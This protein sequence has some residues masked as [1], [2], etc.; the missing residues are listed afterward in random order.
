MI[1]PARTSNDTSSTAGTPRASTTDIP[2][3]VSTSSV[4]FAGVWSMRSSTSRPT[5]IAGDVGLAQAGGGQRADGAP[6]PDHRDLVGDRQHLAQL[7]RDEQHGAAP[8]GE[9]ADDDEE[10]VDLAGREHGRRL[11]EDEQPGVVA[12]ALSTS[13]RWRRPTDRVDTLAAGSTC[14]PKRSL[15][16]RTRCSISGTSREPWRVVSSR[17][18]KTLAATVSEPTSLKC[19][20]TMPMPRASLLRGRDRRLGCRRRRIVARSPAAPSRRSSSSGWSCRRRSPR[21]GRGSRPGSH[22]ERDAVVGDL[23]TVG[24]GDVPQLEQR[25]GHGDADLFRDGSREPWAGPRDA[26]GG[27]GPGAPAHSTR[28]GGSTPE[29]LTAGPSGP[30][31]SRWPP[32][33]RSRR[34]WP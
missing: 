32:G 10:V 18:R 27:P 14:S 26:M 15:S 1:S 25:G 2:R 7:V 28:R 13:T 16:S 22:R 8:A 19:W 29:V 34:P 9:L 31:P 4:G 3:T 6:V 12:S 21:P 24:L 23:R 5:I 33:W 20:W 17:P 11:V 30:G